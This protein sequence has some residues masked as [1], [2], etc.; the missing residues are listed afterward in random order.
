MVNGPRHL[1]QSNWLQ[2]VTCFPLLPS[3]PVLSLVPTFSLNFVTRMWIGRPTTSSARSNAVIDRM[4]ILHMI[5][6]VFDV[7]ISYTDLQ[8]NAA[9][10][11]SLKVS[12][13]HRTWARTSGGIDRRFDIVL[14]VE[15]HC[16]LV[17]DSVVTLHYQISRCIF[18]V[19][20]HTIS[21][22][23]IKSRT[24]LWGFVGFIHTI[25]EQRAVILVYIKY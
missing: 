18:N 10:N 2:E 17:V 9:E 5:A 15:L 6:G 21:V 20:N 23:V 13:A 25:K 24:S 11:P 4:P 7:Q 1:I 12:Q 8:H 19:H 22:I 16:K 14:V 3:Q